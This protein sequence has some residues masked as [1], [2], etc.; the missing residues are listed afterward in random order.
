[1]I[2]N[3]CIKRKGQHRIISELLLFAVGIVITSYV[4]INFN[5]MQDSMKKIAVSDQLETVADIVSAAVVKVAN[6][7]NATI[8]LMVPYLVSGKQYKISLKD[9]DGGKILINTLDGSAYVERQL[10]N[11]D[12]DN[13]ISSNR[14][15]N[16]SEVIS[17]AQFIEIVKNEKI[18]LL[19]VPQ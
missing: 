9:V 10:F 13:T 15:I 4:I 12:Y 7:D 2:N 1:M 16:N 11:I 17:S 14:I 3:R 8:K 5:A 18:T 6:T 19:R